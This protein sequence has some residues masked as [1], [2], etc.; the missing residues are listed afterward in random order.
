VCPANVESNGIAADFPLPVRARTCGTPGTLARGS[1]YEARRAFADNKSPAVP[2]CR[3]D[4]ILRFPFLG[5]RYRRDSNLAERDPE[6]IRRFQNWVNFVKRW[7]RLRRDLRYS[8]GCILQKNTQLMKQ[9]RL[10]ESFASS[11]TDSKRDETCIKIASASQ[12][13]ISRN[14]S[15]EPLDRPDKPKD[16]VQSQDL[17]FSDASLSRSISRLVRECHAPDNEATKYRHCFA[18]STCIQ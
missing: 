7:K 2:L 13:R 18:D 12:Q 11:F 17:R 4:R 16:R 1:V 10:A 5:I 8:E 6:G 15:Q 9:A 3:I 14:R